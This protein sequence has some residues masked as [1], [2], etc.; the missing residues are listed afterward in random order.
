MSIERS[1]KKDPIEE[2]LVRLERGIRELKIAYDRFFAGALPREPLQ[3]R[4]ALKKLIKKYNEE[5]IRAYGHRFRY[6]SLVARFNVMGELW[7]KTV[8]FHEEGDRRANAPK[9]SYDQGVVAKCQIKDPRKQSDALRALYR[10]FVNHRHRN[11]ISGSGSISFSKFLEGVSG[12]ADRLR[13][14]SGCSEIELRLQV[15][16]RKVQVTARPKKK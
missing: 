15:R 4:F 2:D 14:K 3:L 7:N 9:P 5:P 13:Q 6:N 1:S 8:S 16:D 12:Q 11:G 10:E